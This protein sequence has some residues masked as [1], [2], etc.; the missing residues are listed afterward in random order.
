MLW[1]AQLSGRPAERSSPSVCVYLHIS[2]LLVCQQ[3]GL[4]NP[5][6][7]APD[8]FECCR[9]ACGRAAVDVYSLSDSRIKIM[10]VRKCLQR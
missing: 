6:F 9:P 8:T 10:R 1:R 3:I 7:I 2:R 5:F 4:L